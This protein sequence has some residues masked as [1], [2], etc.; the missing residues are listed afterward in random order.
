M[1]NQMLVRNDTSPDQTHVCLDEDGDVV[2]VTGSTVRFHMK[3][4]T[5]GVV[6][7]DAAGSVDDGT[8][9]VVSY[10]WT[11]SDTDTSGWFL[12]EFELTGDGSGDI[13]NGAVESFPKKSF[14]QVFVKGD[15]A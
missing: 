8:A 2:D 9:G 12:A 15:V 13:A 11:A 5:D 3:N 7:V 10:T 4:A 1:S 14:I 6:K